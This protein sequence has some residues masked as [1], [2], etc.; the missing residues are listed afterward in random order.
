MTCVLL[1]Y[2]HA[3]THARTRTQRNDEPDIP[4]ANRAHSTAF[5]KMYLGLHCFVTVPLRTSTA[6]AILQAVPLRV[7][8]FALYRGIN[9]E[10]REAIINQTRIE[11]G[12][13][14]VVGKA[15]F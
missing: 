3:P 15:F 14:D 13:G 2:T 8:V 12:R 9:R 4:L 1:L 7:A 11:S 10:A 5:P 6:E